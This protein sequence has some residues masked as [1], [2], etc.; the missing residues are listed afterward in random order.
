[1]VA[2]CAVNV[3]LA[4][5]MACYQVCNS[6]CVIIVKERLQVFLS[7]LFCLIDTFVTIGIVTVYLFLVFFSVAAIG[8]SSTIGMSIKR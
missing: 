3:A 5:L 6:L 4:A 7:I 1:M 8:G 2:I